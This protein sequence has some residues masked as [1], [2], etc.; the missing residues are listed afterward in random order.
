MFFFF[1][2]F[3]RRVEDQL[4][5]ALVTF[6]QPYAFQTAL[7]LNVSQEKKNKLCMCGLF[8]LLPFI[9]VVCLKGRNDHFAECY[10]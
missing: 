9:L 8:F 3:D 6:G 5:Y 2:F 1:L 4:P 10:L 7:L